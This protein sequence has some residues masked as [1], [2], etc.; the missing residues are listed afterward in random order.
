MAE[1]DRFP[2]R[3]Q[4]V[5]R[6]WHDDKEIERADIAPRRLEPK[7][8]EDANRKHCEEHIHAPALRDRIG[9]V[10]EVGETVAH[11]GP[12]GADFRPFSRRHAGF[13]IGAAPHRV[14]EYEV[15]DRWYQPEDEQ[16]TE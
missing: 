1:A 4:D 8:P 2:A 12:A 9:A 5:G 13:A 15:D 6:D 7:H 10:D 3:Q 14:N 11:E 16:R